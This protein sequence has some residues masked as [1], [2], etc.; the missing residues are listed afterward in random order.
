MTHLDRARL[1]SIII[2]P[3]FTHAWA[4]E[5]GTPLG[6]RHHMKIHWVD[7]DLDVNRGFWH[8]AGA[9][10][11][12]P[13]WILHLL[14]EQLSVL[15]RPSCESPGKLGWESLGKS[16]QFSNQAGTRGPGRDGSSALLPLLSLACRLPSRTF[17]CSVSVAD[18]PHS[19]SNNSPPTGHLPAPHQVCGSDGHGRL[20]LLAP[21]HIRRGPW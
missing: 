9:G 15:Y 18:Y 7:L 17:I 21:R 6:A 10:L 2:S 20:L 5:E 13:G 8:T 19:Y 3:L 12:G 16:T 11:H 1:K 14:R 4:R